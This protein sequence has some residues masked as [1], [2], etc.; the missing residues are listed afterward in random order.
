MTTKEI[1]DEMYH[2]IKMQ[3]RLEDYEAQASEDVERVAALKSE[4]KKIMSILSM[5]GEQS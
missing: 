2:C 3:K 5:L 1:L 4:Y